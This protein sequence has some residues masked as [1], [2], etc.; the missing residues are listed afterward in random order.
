MA[1]KPLPPD[2]FCP[3]QIPSCLGREAASL[4]ARLVQMDITSEIR[5][6]VRQ[7]GI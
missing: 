3:H 5:V 7:N 4:V 2:I 1:K 6:S